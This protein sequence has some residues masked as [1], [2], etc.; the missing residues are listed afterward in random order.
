MN[1]KP[2][3]LLYS[4]NDAAH[5]LSISRVTVYAEINAKRLKFIQF[6]SRKFITRDA[7]NEWIRNRELESI[8]QNHNGFKTK[9]SPYLVPAFDAPRRQGGSS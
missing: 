2:E 6:K 9:D 3:K 7:L 1:S 5:V 4:I 8:G